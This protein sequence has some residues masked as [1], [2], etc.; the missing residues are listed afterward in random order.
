MEQE[1]DFGFVFVEKVPQVLA[2]KEGRDPRKVEFNGNVAIVDNVSV[3]SF[4]QRVIVGDFKNTF[5]S[6]LIDL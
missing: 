3:E 6:Y 2:E 5:F 1:E 4:W